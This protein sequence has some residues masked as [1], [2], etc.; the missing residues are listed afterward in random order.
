MLTNDFD[1]HLPEELIAQ[2]PLID[3]SSSRLLVVNRAGN[4][5]VHE[6]F[7]NI[8]EHLREGDVMVFNQS[9]VIPARFYGVRDDTNGKVEILLLRKVKHLIW[10]ALARPGK[11]LRP[12]TYISILDKEGER[13]GLQIEVMESDLHGIK[14]IRMSTENYIDTLGHMPLPPYIQEKL[15]D[16][17]RYQTVYAKETGSVAAPTAG[18]HFTNDMLKD[19]ENLGVITAYVTLHVGLDTFRPVQEDNPMD[20]HIH[21]E[22]Y[23]IDQSTATILN[24]AKEEN[25]RIIAVGTTSV[26][27]LEQLGNNMMQ[28][29]SKTIEPTSGDADIFILPGHKFK[30]VDAM[31]TN[32]H[33][34]KST[35]L[36][37]VSAFASYSQIK[38]VY[39]EAIREKYRFYSFGDAMFIT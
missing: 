2:T 4:S 33:L 27:V 31:V 20:H 10:Q 14:T 11:R 37:L 29:D 32:F 16:P 38:E 5:L 6:T 30:Y 28:S 13:S 3:R 12:G 1:Y 36:M 9:K 25:R 8:T 23:E 7:N 19:I 22:Y 39:S 24:N 17:A 15:E 26:R 35:L 34:P 21:T 18:L